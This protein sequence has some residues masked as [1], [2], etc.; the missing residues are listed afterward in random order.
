[1][2]SN[3][4]ASAIS[5]PVVIV[6]MIAL[7]ALGG[8]WYYASKPRAVA[9]PAPL[10]ADAKA[11]VRNLKLAG[12]TMN[13][14]KSFAGGELVEIVG[15]ITNQGDRELKR[16]ELTCIFADPAGTPLL[17]D[18]VAIVRTSIKPG[19]T[20]AFRLPFEGIPT[21]WNQALPQMV[22]AHI[23]FT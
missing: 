20:K 3:K 16:V 8:W 7:A 17:R 22:I 14:S 12:V 21:S 6:A 4:P 13:A 5:A 9:A 18:R 1:M 19:E 2:A 11:Y 23:E 10:T 15:N